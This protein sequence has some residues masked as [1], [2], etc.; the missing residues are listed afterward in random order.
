MKKL[1]LLSIATLLGGM[2]A[3]QS[4]PDGGFE[5][6]NTTTWQDPNFY[7]TSN[8]QNVSNG[9]APNVTQ[10]AGWHGTYGVKLTTIAGPQAGFIINGNPNNNGI[11]GGIPSGW[12]SPQKPTGVRF[13]YKYAPVGG[14]TAAVLCI[15]K[16]GGAQI[17]SFLIILPVAEANYTLHTYNAHTPLTMTPDT[18][19]FAAASSFAA[20]NNG[21]GHVGSTFVI[22]SVTFTGVPNQPADMNGDFE[23][24]NSDTMLTPPGWY[25]NYP[26]VTFTTDASVGTHALQIATINN[27]QRG[28][29][30]NGQ[31][32][33]GYYPNC[34]G[35]CNEQGGQPYSETATKKDTLYFDYKYA[36]MLHDTASISLTFIKNGLP[37]SY[38]G[39]NYSA[40]VSSYTTASIPFNLTG[41]SPVPDTVI[42][43]I[44]S[45]QHNHD[46]TNAQYAP[47]VGTVLKIDNMYLGSQRVSLGINS[48]SVA[49]GIKVYPN[50]AQTQINVDVTN[51]SGS[52]QSISL[53]DMSGR[54]LSMNNYSG[55]VRNG[56]Q[57]IDISGFSAGIYLIEATTSNGKFYQKVCKN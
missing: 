46:T 40:T 20:I 47:Y 41:V 54:M 25:I 28:G 57:T 24:W 37:V 14:D 49:Q 56:V 3:A 17:D 4:I 18:V 27:P 1:L 53:Y 11:T 48:V 33:T 55:A 23:T 7:T 51:I 12:S 2:L 9:F 30:Q 6:W 10:T 43:N 45:S 31:A 5:Y 21:G 19:I 22:D 32:G 15:F 39:N 52:L 36:P 34:H 50:P 26:C 42:V 38:A 16:K 35:M 29:A 8:D 44:N 13:Y